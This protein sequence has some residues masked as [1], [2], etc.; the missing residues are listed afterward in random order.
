MGSASS[1]NENIQDNHS[2]AKTP[3]TLTKKEKVLQIIEKSKYDEYLE[4]SDMDLT[5]EDIPE[6]PEYINHLYLDNNKLTKIPQLHDQIT[7]LD[8]SNNLISDINNLP[9]KI[10]YLYINNNNL[11]EIPD[12]YNYYNLSHIYA[13]NNKITK[14]VNFPKYVTYVVLNNN[15]I[16]ELPKLPE[17]LHLLQVYNNKITKI[18][19]IPKNTLIVLAKNP[20]FED[21]VRVDNFNTESIETRTFND[22]EFKVLTLKKGTVLFRTSSSLDNGFKDMFV[23]YRKD[24]KYIISPEHESYFFLHPFNIS[25]GNTTIIHVLTSDVKLIMGINPS[26]LISKKEINKK[27]G[28]TCKTKNY[29]SMIKSHFNTFC[30]SD[31]FVRQNPDIL[32]WIAPDISSSIKHNETFDTL[33]SSGIGSY[34]S[35][36]ENSEGLITRPEVTV[37]PFRERKLVDVET[38]IEDFSVDKVY[39][40]M[41]LYNYKPFLIIEDSRDIK[42]YKKYI[43]K[44]LSKRGYKDESGSYHMKRREDGTYYIEEML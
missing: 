19:K 25:Y 5:D 1:K 6:I 11:T 26:K 40:N 37:Y 31:E 18:G 27:F 22:I 12:L 10:S 30:I 44:L 32:G 28:Q 29:K 8:L 34:I 39:E 13:N 20:I 17:S 16:E 21:K 43:D 14:I 41:D 15:L 7:N 4:L 3:K 2:E 36:Y 33:G 38:K 24:N 42:V 9:S 23:G 35:Y